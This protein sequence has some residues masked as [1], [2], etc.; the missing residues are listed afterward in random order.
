MLSFVCL[1]IQHK[2]SI[3]ISWLKKILLEDWLTCFSFCGNHWCLG[4]RGP[5]R[6]S[7]ACG[8]CSQDLSERPGSGKK[9]TLLVY[10]LTNHTDSYGCRK[11]FGCLVG[12]DAKGCLVENA[13][14][15]TS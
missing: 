1:F 5:R 10:H 9:K 7:R 14:G 15:R 11:N 13:A 3:F 4:K 6:P 2:Q 12:S 8:G